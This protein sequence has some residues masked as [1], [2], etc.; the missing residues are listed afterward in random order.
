MSDKPLVIYHYPCQDGFTAAW[1]I[2][3][4]HPDWEFYPMKHGN[5]LPDLSGRKEIYFVDF[6]PKAM[7]IYNLFQLPIHPEKIVI[8][9]HHK[10]AQEELEKTRPLDPQ[11]LALEIRFDMNKSG[12]KL[13]WECFH[14]ENPVPEIVKYVEDRDLWKFQY[15]PET[16]AIT[17][18]IFSY[19]YDFETWDALSKDLEFSDEMLVG[20]G[21]SIL[22]KQAKDVEELSQ[23]K[24]RYIIGGH[25]VWLVNV[26]YTLASDM[27][28]LLGKGEPFA[29]TFFYDGEGYVFSLRSD[30][31]GLDVS[32]IAKQYGGGGH[33]HAAG[34]KL[35]SPLV[36]IDPKKVGLE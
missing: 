14:P 1:A 17:A 34:F 29:A 3:K 22:R 8:L 7:D 33:K 16:Q 23:G 28:H 26:P 36:L 13:A 24:F 25:E 18:A 9:D 5:Q 4:A 21:N 32:E 12:A 20:E 30:D 31:N 15:A 35:K 6:S 11:G 10:T 19:P 27:G 2:W